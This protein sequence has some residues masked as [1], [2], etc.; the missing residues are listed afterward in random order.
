M[1]H[2]IYIYIYIFNHHIQRG[3]L[4]K[5]FFGGGGEN[6]HCLCHPWI[7]NRAEWMEYE[8]S[9]M[10]RIMMKITM[11]T[12]NMTTTKTTITKTIKITTKKTTSPK[13]IS[14]ETAM[15]KT[16]NKSDHNRD[17]HNRENF[18]SLL[19]LRIGFRPECYYLHTLRG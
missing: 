19:T 10:E 18:F 15:M 6:F 7:L 14:T 1:Y 2:H 8:I 11:S 12:T 16:T 9:Y 17:E 4:F 3:I 5:V 13:N